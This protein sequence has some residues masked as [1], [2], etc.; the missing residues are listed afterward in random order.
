MPI[1]ILI[2][3]PAMNLFD[4][5]SILSKMVTKGFALQHQEQANPTKEARKQMTMH[6]LTLELEYWRM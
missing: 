3:Y 5:V 6:R 4:D 1:S 2:V